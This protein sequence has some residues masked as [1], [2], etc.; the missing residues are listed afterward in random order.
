MRGI[1]GAA[2]SAGLAL[3]AALSQA[4]PARAEP[5]PE[6]TGNWAGPSNQGFYFRAALEQSAPD[7][8]SLLIWNG[9]DAVPARAGEPALNVP[10]FALSAFVRAQ[11]LQL[12]EDADG[13]TLQVVT[14]FADE[15]AEGREVVSIQFLDFQYTVVG[16]SHHSEEYA[17]GGGTI[18]YACDID[19]RGGKVTENGTTRDLPAMDFEATN[20]SGWHFAV[21]F[22]R[23]WCGIDDPGDGDA[24]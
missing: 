22:D 14:D 6:V 11:G 18:P 17:E 9:N 2:F 16:Y 8:V 7:S 3:V 10:E 13:T 4:S 19:F 15:V 5:A 21:A 23:G 20:A 12:V 24:G 1:S